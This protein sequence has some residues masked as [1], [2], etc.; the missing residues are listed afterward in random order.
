MFAKNATHISQFGFSPLERLFPPG[1]YIAKRV[2]P[3]V[4]SPRMRE[5]AMSMLVTP[6]PHAK[7]NNRAAG[8]PVHVNELTPTTTF[9]VRVYGNR[10]AFEDQPERRCIAE[11][12]EG[13]CPRPLAI[14]GH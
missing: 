3:W 10:S 4:F 7:H 11:I 6:W 12:F 13:F 5:A 9:E 2:C 8:H 14:G 1:E